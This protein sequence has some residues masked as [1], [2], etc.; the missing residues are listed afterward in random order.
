METRQYPA[1]TLTFQYSVELADTQELV[2]DPAL[3]NFM[4]FNDVQANQLAA[5]QKK[6]DVASPEG[7]KAAE[8]A[9]TYMVKNAFLTPV[10]NTEALMFSTKDAKVKFG[11]YPW[12]DPTQWTPAN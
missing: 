3:Y 8:A 10:S 6:Y 5:N 4:A 11:T 2:T 7:I 12:P 1:T 9:S